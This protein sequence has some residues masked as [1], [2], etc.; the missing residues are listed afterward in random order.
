MLYMMYIEDKDDNY[1]KLYL[2][3][4]IYIS[5]LEYIIDIHVGINNMYSCRTYVLT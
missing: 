5:V 4:S 3:T 2:T 1:N